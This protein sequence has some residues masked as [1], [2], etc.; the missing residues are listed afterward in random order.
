MT[1]TTTETG[2][3]DGEKFT[4]IY[5]MHHLYLHPSNSPGSVLIHQQ[6]TGIENNTA[7]SNSMRVAL[8]AKNKLGFIDGKCRKEQ[9]SG[10]LE[11]EWERCNAFVLS[12]ITNSVSKELANGIMYSTNDCS[13]WTDLKER[14]DKKNLTRVYQLLREICTTSQRS[15]SIL[16]YYSKLKCTWDEY[17]SMVSLPCD[18][19]KHKE[20]AE[21]MEQQRLVQ[22]L[23]GLN[24]TYAQ[25]RSQVLLTVP[26]PTLNQAY[27]MI[28]QDESQ[29]VQSN[30]IS[31]VAPALQQLD[32]NDS[33]ALA[34]I[35][36]NR[37]RINNG[38][39]A[40]Q[41][42]YYYI[43]GHKKENCYKLVGYPSNNK[44]N[45]RRT[46]D[47]GN[48]GG[49]MGPTANNVS[50]IDEFEGTSLVDGLSG[51]PNNIPFFTPEQYHQLLKLIDKEP[52][53]TDAKANMAGIVDLLNAC[54]SVGS[55]TN[56]WVIDTG[57]SNHVVSSLD[58]LTDSHS[59]ASNSSKVHLPNG[60][61][62]SIT[63]TG[64]LTLSNDLELYNVLYVPNF[65]YN[66][67]SVSKLTKELKC[68]ALI[69]HEFCI[70]QSLYNSRVS[71][72]GKEKDG[73]YILQPAKIPPP[74]KVPDTPSA[75]ALNSFISSATPYPNILIPESSNITSKPCSHP[76]IWHQRLG[77]APVAVLQK[78]PS[79]KTHL[80]N[81]DNLNCIVCPLARQTRFPFPTSTKKSVCSFDLV[82]MDVW[83]PYRQCT[84]NGYKYFLTI[85][86]DYSRMT[87]IYLMK[88][89]SDVFLLLI[90]FLALVKN[91]FSTTIKI[92][93]SDNGLEFFN[94]QC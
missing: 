47:N 54:L 45:K 13:V 88:M 77:H 80:L 44:F 36:S 21:H 1:N 82:H 84:Y 78:I 67:L 91:Q 90:S 20:Y 71:G 4:N 27:N 14:F 3:D 50:C 92:I 59:V 58:I 57:A 11:H 64:S 43:K 9:Y 83:G 55:E 75:P 61:T 63:H 86:D 74:V 17:W 94:S 42:D 32:L 39:S 29:R 56:P 68:C 62:T 93:R 16:E 30:M 87:W 24:E 15:L 22:F 81:K 18:C 19:T 34:F 26:V 60:N 51:G 89:K 69:F 76:S 7:W 79:L 41:C 33:T 38:N 8:L 53:T 66:L 35:Q 10:D 40:L 85:V 28:M 23:M 72:I 12:W 49:S 46:F 73:L 48:S 25:A 6:L 31:Q 2:K 5:P 70:F 37:F 65:K 52:S